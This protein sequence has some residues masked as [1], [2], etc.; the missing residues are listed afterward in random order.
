VHPQD[1]TGQCLLKVVKLYKEWSLPERG[2]KHASQHTHCHEA[3]EACHTAPSLMLQSRSSR[4]K[5]AF[6]LGHMCL[7]SPSDSNAFSVS[8]APAVPVAR[9]IAT[10]RMLN[11]NWHRNSVLAQQ[12][13]GFG[14]MRSTIVYTYIYTASYSQLVRTTYTYTRSPMHSRC[15]PRTARKNCPICQTLRLFCIMRL[16]GT[17]VMDICRRCA[18][19]TS[20]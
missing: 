1:R 8:E 5:S 9:G 4:G 20:H 17:T 15:K 11:V 3:S 18:I 6:V 10:L 13:P 7:L 19:E 12:V 2:L 16:I 14:V